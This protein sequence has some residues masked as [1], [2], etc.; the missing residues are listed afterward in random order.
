[1]AHKGQVTFSWDLS[2]IT[3]GYFPLK[4]SASMMFLEHSFS[5]TISFVSDT[6]P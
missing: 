3:P 4:P 6:L 1:M 2:D 5:F